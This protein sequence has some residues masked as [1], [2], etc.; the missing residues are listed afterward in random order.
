MFIL[1]PLQNRSETKISLVWGER[2]FLFFCLLKNNNLSRA[3][4]A[5]FLLKWMV[6]RNDRLYAFVDLKVTT[7]NKM[8]SSVL[9]EPRF[10]NNTLSATATLYCKVTQRILVLQA[11][12]TNT[13]K[14]QQNPLFFGWSKGRTEN[15]FLAS[16]CKTTKNQNDFVCHFSSSSNEL[17]RCWLNTNSILGW[18]VWIRKC[19]D[20]FSDDL[21]THSR[22][23]AKEDKESAI[24]W[25]HPL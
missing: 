2:R 18:C 14:C 10:L 19:W 9:R 16:I 17:R 5:V 7:C 8:K 25:N 24:S 1:A 12:T 3:D 6:S 21:S 13:Q 11:T 20:Y 15:V 22:L 23:M 4:D